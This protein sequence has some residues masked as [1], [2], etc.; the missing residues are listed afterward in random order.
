MYFLFCL[1]AVDYKWYLA[2]GSQ[3]KIHVDLL[4]K[5]AEVIVKATNFNQ[6]AEWLGVGVSMDN[7]MVSYTWL[8]TLG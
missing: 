6:G 1:L 2:D 8:L 5:N 4:T 3:V 7:K